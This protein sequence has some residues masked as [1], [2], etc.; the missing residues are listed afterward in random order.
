MEI[1]NCAT[2]H[3]GSLIAIKSAQV[4]LIE[5][6][7]TAKTV[8]RTGWCTFIWTAFFAINAQCAMTADKILPLHAIEFY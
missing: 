2:S 3:L 5:I 1:K 6:Y 8:R 4:S 7:V